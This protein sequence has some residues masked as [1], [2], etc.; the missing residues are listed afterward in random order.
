MIME[1]PFDAVLQTTRNLVH[2]TF[3]LLPKLVVAMLV[4][5]VCLSLARFAESTCIKVFQ[6]RHRHNLGVVIGRLTYWLGAFVAC[7]VCLSIVTPSFAAGDLIQMLGISGVAIGFAFKDVFQN[8][9][10]GLIILI[11]E[12]FKLGDRIT[13]GA[14]EGIVSDIETRATV[15]LGDDGSRIILP[16][17]LVF[18]SAVTV[19]K[20]ASE[21][22]VVRSLHG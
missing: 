2:E 13:V 19:G 3:A 21:D 17:T 15:L 1:S 20:R 11:S 4:L 18:T 5:A 9:L 16:N 14:F 12:P 7:M 10:A 6:H 22:S 8:F